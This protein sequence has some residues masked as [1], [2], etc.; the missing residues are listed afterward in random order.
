MRPLLDLTLVAVSCVPDRGGNIGEPA[1]ASQAFEDL[2]VGGVSYAGNQLLQLLGED[3]VVLLRVEG[4]VVFLEPFPEGSH[5][6]CM[7]VGG[8]LVGRSA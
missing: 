2:F 3:I 7:V 4:V 5:T 1:E 8:G 6:L